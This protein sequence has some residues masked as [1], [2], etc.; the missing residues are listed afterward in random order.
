[1]KFLKKATYIAYVIAELSKN[2][3]ISMQTSSDSLFRKDSL[4]T[5][6]GQE[7]VLRSHF[8]CNFL[9]NSFLWQY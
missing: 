9:I 4:K 1:M 2:F 6:K 8:P 5:K 3:Q 7:V